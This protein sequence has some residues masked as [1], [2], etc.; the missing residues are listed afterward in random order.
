MI[1]NQRTILIVDDCPE[2]RETYRRYLL[3]DSRY[4]Y[5]I[6]ESEY[7]EDGLE[8]C[9]RVGCDAILLDFLLPDIDGI[10]FLNELK[11]QLGR[12]NLPVV[13]L[14][15]Q[16][17]EAIAVQVMKSGASDYLVKGN[18]TPESLR[19]AIHSVVERT[20]LQ[21]L[22]EQSEQRF[23]TSVENMLDCFGIY[24]SVRDQS[25]RIVDFLV[26]YVN[27]AACANHCIIQSE[28]IGK[29]L[30]E[31]LPSQPET[32]LFD[33]YCQV[34][35]TGEPLFKEALVYTDSDNKQYLTKA[36]D[37]RAAKLGDGL[38]ASWRDITDRKQA[39]A[40][41]QQLN[42]NLDRQVQE[43]TAQL[44]QALEFEAM[45]KRITDK[46]R[47]SLD[48]SQ[49]WQTAVQELALGLD[50]GGCNA[51]W[52]NLDEGTSTICY[53]YVTTIPAYRRQ[54]MQMAD[55][56]E[57]YR[58]LLGG[59][60]FQFCSIVPNPVRG[61]VA[62]LACPIMNDEGVLG[63]LWLIN[64]KDYAFNDLEIRLV[65]QVANQCAIAI[66]QARLYQAATAQV[67]ELEKLNRLK[68]DFLSTVSHELRTPVTNMKMAI[69][70]LQIA[71][72][73]EQRERYLKVL[74]AECDRELELINNLLDL[75]Q[76]Q[77]MAYISDL[78]P[79]NLHDWLPG[80]IESFQMRTEERQQI[81]RVVLPPSLQPLNSD[82]ASLGRI[83]AELL[84]NAYKYT[85]VGGEIVLSV[86][87]NSASTI[88]TI[89]NSAEI[90]AAELP[91]IFKKF[92]R[93]PNAN[94]W[95]H[96]GTGL[97]LALVQKLIERLQGTIKVESS[98]GW[99]RFTV[100]LPNQP[101]SET[102]IVPLDPSYE[103]SAQGEGFLAD[104]F[105]RSL[106]LPTA[107]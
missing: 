90:P 49:I 10:E 22:L 15:G 40:A 68:D 50:L 37:I 14:T 83:L 84:N 61:R 97:G 96:S 5:T 45:L 41:L 23:R 73:L 27:A 103:F 36:F 52:Y 94:P 18:M 33:E 17:N 62:M 80:I 58:Q 55:F 30:L 1:H 56:P 105:P 81:L 57:I 101:I 31:L 13:M 46:V 60:Y 95:Q 82:R 75:Q 100:Q 102:E 67:E 11:I 86:H 2:D 88:F 21:C 28:Q 12:T 69:H 71:P 4:T 42:A 53:E 106:I 54:A 59:Q 99:T 44:Q 19:L 16:G 70:M 87:H 48:E 29:R 85:P 3:Q 104:S 32:E 34:V 9:R 25:G 8:L 38:V 26:E 43:R 6:L 35:E 78:E 66:R 79:V 93:I 47:D 51:A 76:L 65:Q 63:D 72:A 24:M 98:S 89:S 74:R 20:H 39:E 107:E 77:A 92:Y 7:G 91:N 64:H